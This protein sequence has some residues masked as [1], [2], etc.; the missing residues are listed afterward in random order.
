MESQ[1]ILCGGKNSWRG[2][3]FY[4]KVHNRRKKRVAVGVLGFYFMFFISLI[5]RPVYLDILS[6]DIP[7]FNIIKASSN[8]PFF[9]S[10]FSPSLHKGQKM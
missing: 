10:I 9:L 5:D 7:S 3:Y 4:N 2:K 8:L 1:V 6:N